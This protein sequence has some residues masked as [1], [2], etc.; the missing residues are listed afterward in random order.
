MCSAE[1]TQT[2][3]G[4]ELHTADVVVKFCDPFVAGTPDR[5]DR[6]FGDMDELQEDTDYVVE[7][8]EREA[9]IYTRLQSTAIV[10]RLFG[11]WDGV[12]SIIGHHRLLVMILENV[13]ASLNPLISLSRA[14]NLMYDPVYRHG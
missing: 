12:S 9:I 8:V 14:G 7:S 6:D 13:G 5:F 1:L 3:Y 11:L 2:L 4:G 10:P